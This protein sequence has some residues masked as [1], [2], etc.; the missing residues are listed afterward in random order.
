[1]TINVS[2]TNPVTVEAVSNTT[3]TSNANAL[4]DFNASI[5]GTVDSGVTVDGFGLQ[6]VSTS[7][8]AGTTIQITN[9]GTVSTNQ[10][11]IHALSANAGPGTNF[12]TFT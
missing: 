11:S 5:I 4:E 1:M 6:F 7:P 2:G 12:G 9:D 8:V 3:T 10:N